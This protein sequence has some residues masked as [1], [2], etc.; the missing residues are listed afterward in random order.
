[1]IE[2]RKEGRIA[3]ITINRPEGLGALTARGHEEL[4]QAYLNLRNDDEVLVGIITGIGKAFCSGSDIKDTLPA[5]KK[6]GSD[7]PWDM[8]TPVTMR[9]L[10]LWKPL[11]AAVNGLTLGGGMG[12]ILGCDIRIASE[13]AKFGYPEVKIGLPPLEGSTQRLPHIV[14]LGVA[15]ELILTG[16]VI[17][18]QEAYRIGL[19][20]KVVPPDE[21]MSAAKGVAQTLC[22]A[23]PL[24]VKVAKEQMIRGLG[25]SLEDGLTFE[26][27]FHRRILQTKDF[28]E[29][30]AAFQEKRKPKFEG[31]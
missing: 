12:V 21:L 25:M 13:N 10:E 27:S 26:F 7:R 6:A 17:D 20:T 30:I 5:V 9:G 1:M 22:E 29:G 2:Y 4:Y 31:R 24:A 8:P 14:G 11:I 16:R 15:E 3:I 23:A 18:A 19:V 28:E